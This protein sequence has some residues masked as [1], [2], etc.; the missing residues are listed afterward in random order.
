MKRIDLTMEEA[1]KVL[2]ERGKFTLQDNGQNCVITDY[3]K[4]MDYARGLLLG[5]L[6]VFCKAGVLK[7]EGDNATK[8]QIRDAIKVDFPEESF[9]N[10]TFIFFN[11]KMEYKNL[12]VYEVLNAMSLNDHIF[13]VYNHEEF[14]VQDG[15]VGLSV[16]AKELMKNNPNLLVIDEIR[17]NINETILPVETLETIFNTLGVTY[18]IKLTACKCCGYDLGEGYSNCNSEGIC[19]ECGTDVDQAKCEQCEQYDFLNENGLCQNCQEMNN[20]NDKKEGLTVGFMDALKETHTLE[21]NNCFVEVNADES[22]DVHYQVPLKYFSSLNFD[23]PQDAFAKFDELTEKAK[24][25]VAWRNALEGSQGVIKV[26][27]TKVR[28]ERDA[29]TPA[30]LVIEAIK[31][32]AFGE[33][34]HGKDVSIELIELM[35]RA[36]LTNVDYFFGKFNVDYDKDDSLE[37]NMICLGSEILRVAKKEQADVVPEIETTVDKIEAFKIS[38]I[39]ATTVGSTLAD[40]LSEKYDFED[41]IEGKMFFEQFGFDYKDY[42]SLEENLLG[43]GA[44]IV[45]EMKFTLVRKINEIY[46]LNPEECNE[47]LFLT[48]FKE[49]VNDHNIDFISEKYG[50]L[51][52]DEAESFSRN[53]RELSDM[54]YAQLA[55][56]GDI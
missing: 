8:E 17:K 30:D 46:S 35:E 10:D 16:L 41:P 7:I 2:R 20:E 13:L 43:L 37:E 48:K 55:A 18:I 34:L 15:Q 21:Q 3:S 45:R 49:L 9:L 5:N 27:T 53:V 23:T 51:K 6:D 50:F 56:E 19:P 54:I 28:I 29:T 32:F 42:D 40:E 24:I 4:L 31:L 36:G 14:F 52:Y 11:I 38:Q 44:Y 39:D 25:D 22:V 26:T 33:G 47:D 12:S 1:T